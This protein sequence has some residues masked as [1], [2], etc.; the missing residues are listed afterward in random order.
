MSL[1]IGNTAR[2]FHVWGDDWPHWNE[3]YTA[4]DYIQAYVYKWSRCRLQS[5]EKWGTLRYERVLPPCKG[6]GFTITAPWKKKYSWAKEPIH[7]IIYMWS[8][9]WLYYKWMWCGTKM[10]RRAVD[11][12]CILYPNVV[13]EITDDLDW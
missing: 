8:D 10:L 11:K 13:K 3:L 1:Q 2:T 7:P 5:K 4:E 6:C 9:S 12:A